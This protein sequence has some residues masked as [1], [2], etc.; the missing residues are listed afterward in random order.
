MLAGVI[1]SGTTIALGYGPPPTY[2]STDRIYAPGINAA[3]GIIPAGAL[4]ADTPPA[5]WESW[6]AEV[7]AKL[8]KIADNQAAA[9]K[10]AAGKPSVSAGGRI[11]VD[12]AAFDQ[13]DASLVQA[14]DCLNGTEFRRA[15]IFLKGKVSI[16]AHPSEVVLRDLTA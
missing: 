9:K 15:R 3:H 5:D 16:H 11:M 10:K 14:G 1:V 6:K 12:W 13:N 7:D 4:N 2:P 8:K